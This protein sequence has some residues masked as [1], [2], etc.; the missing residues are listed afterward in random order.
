MC[1]V[2]NFSY[3]LAIFIYT[4]ACLQKQVHFSSQNILSHVLQFQVS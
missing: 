4:Q 1:V 3:Y 2:K